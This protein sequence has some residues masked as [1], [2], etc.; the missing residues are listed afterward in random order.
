MGHDTFKLMDAL[1]RL[2]SD[3]DV[4]WGRMG[5]MQRW[6]D[7]QGQQLHTLHNQVD[8]GLTRLDALLAGAHRRR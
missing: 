1:N 7:S 6:L 4:Q 3:I 5:L 8:E 2:D